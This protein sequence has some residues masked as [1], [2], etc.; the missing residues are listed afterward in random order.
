MYYGGV[1]GI[2]R[3]IMLMNA[4]MS[5]LLESNDA[6]GWLSVSILTF[7]IAMLMFDGKRQVS[8]FDFIWLMF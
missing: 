6:S 1:V 8:I 3:L 2:S 7:G 4:R 5:A